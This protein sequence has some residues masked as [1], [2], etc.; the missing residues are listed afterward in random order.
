MRRSTPKNLF[1]SLAAVTALVASSC[2]D[3]T[4]D[5]ATERTETTATPA[6]AGGVDLEAFCAEAQGLKDDGLKYAGQ[7]ARHAAAGRLTA[8]AKVAPDEVRADVEVLVAFWVDADENNIGPSVSGPDAAESIRPYKELVERHPKA[9]EAGE[10][11]YAFVG[12]NCGFF[13]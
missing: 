2:D 7:E 1:V 5:S 6:A 9:R 10:R 3:G 12:D 8:M 4:A 11:F 13:F